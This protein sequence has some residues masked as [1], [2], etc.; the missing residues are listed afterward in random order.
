MS[1]TEIFIEPTDGV[2]MLWARATG[3]HLHERWR[4]AVEAWRA[5]IEA[6]PPSAKQD[7]IVFWT[8]L[9]MAAKNAKATQ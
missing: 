3:L 9:T 7:L 8:C 5:V 2:R 1:T 4:E 6:W